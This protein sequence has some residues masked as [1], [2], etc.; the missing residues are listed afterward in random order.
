MNVCVR[1][2]VFE[3]SFKEVNSLS[4]LI[5]VNT[6]GAHFFGGE[7]RVYIKGSKD[8]CTGKVMLMEATII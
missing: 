6:E 1:L 7:S 2:L 3:L 5:F 8:W 4:F